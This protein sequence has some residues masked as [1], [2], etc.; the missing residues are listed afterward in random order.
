MNNSSLIEMTGITKRFPGVVANEHV[1]FNLRTGEI[2]SLLGENGA[3]K[4][5][6]MNILSGMLQPDSGTIAVG[7]N[8]VRI[9]SPLDA[10]KLGIGMVYQHFTL[11]P[12]LTV[13]ENLILGFEDSFF[14]NLKKAELK[15]QHI[16]KTYGLSIDPQKKI[17]DLSVS[18]RQRTEI[19]KILFHGSDILILDEPTSVLSPPEVEDLFHTLKSLRKDGK[20]VVLIT[21]NLNEALAISDHITIMRSGKR[22]AELSSDAL[23]AMGEKSASEQILELM[24]EAFSQSEKAGNK[25]IIEDKSVLELKQVEAVNS[26]GIVGLKRIS[27]SVRKGEILGITGVDSEG[28]RLLAEVIGGQKRVSAGKLIFK[29]QDITDLKTARRFELGISTVTDDRINKGCVPDMKLSENSILH[30]YYL[31]PFSRY[32]ALKQSAIQSFTRD[33]IRRFAIQ[34]TGPE[35]LVGTLSGGNIQKF[36]LARGLCAKPGL[37]VCNRPTYGLDVKTVRYVQHLLV[38]ESKRGTAILLITADMNELFT[39]SH[40]IGVLFNGELVEVM[41]SGDATH[42]RVAKLMIGIRR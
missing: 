22:V 16:S 8:K 39:C 41:D 17:Q 30:N 29:G 27:F 10:I 40:R 9:R 23:L 2:H 21:H 37:I 11:T 6:L 20:S 42:E 34:T 15:L 4:T 7:N 18:E 19:L 26:R 13:L 35:A 24:F 33:L 38:E 28:Q 5:T 32:G 3:G 12:N 31:P 36:I 25:K 1:D 14:L